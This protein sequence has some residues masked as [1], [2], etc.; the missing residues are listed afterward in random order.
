[1]ARKEGTAPKPAKR[2]LKP[3]HEIELV[4]E[5]VRGPIEDDDQHY[6][7]EQRQSMKKKNVRKMTTMDKAGKRARVRGV[8]AEQTIKEKDEE[9][10]KKI[11]FCCHV[12]HCPRK[13][14]EKYGDDQNVQSSEVGLYHRRCCHRTV[15]GRISES[16]TPEIQLLLHALERVVTDP[17]NS[18][19]SITFTPDM[20]L[21]EEI[22]ENGRALTVTIVGGGGG[23]NDERSVK[24]CK[25]VYNK[26]R[27]NRSQENE[28][29]RLD[30]QPCK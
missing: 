23:D 12:C 6:F 10:E 26:Y 24:D 1:M 21:T 30:L 15:E 22:D 28:M 25:T 9:V 8:K 13:V 27:T 16:W 17:E 7:E 14:K 5:K 3:D 18:P 11:A 20:D 2:I 19:S 4:V 29:R